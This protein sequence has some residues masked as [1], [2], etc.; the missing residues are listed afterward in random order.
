MTVLLYFWKMLRFAVHMPRLWRLCWSDCGK[1]T[2]GKKDNGGNAAMNPGL[3][4]RKLKHI[5]LP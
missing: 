4:L 3:L 5:Q 1:M 2:S